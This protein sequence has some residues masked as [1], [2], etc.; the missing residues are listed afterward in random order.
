MSSRGRPATIGIL[1]AASL[2]VVRDA[3]AQAT[4]GAWQIGLST[5]ALSYTKTTITTDGP[6]FSNFDN[7]QTSF[8]WGFGERSNLGLDLGHG[9]GDNFVLGAFLALQGQAQSQ[10]DRITGRSFRH[11]EFS[12]VAGPRLDWLPLP[13]SKVRPF[14]GVG[15]GIVRSNHSDDSSTLST[16]ADP[17]ARPIREESPSGMSGW[18]LVS[19]LGIRW[20]LNPHFSIDPALF[21]DGSITSDDGDGTGYELRQTNLV[22]GL[23]I[24]GSGWI[25][26]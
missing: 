10:N 5:R 14:I 15:A 26:P 12:L 6:V 3:G 9:L 17:G 20:F 24:G 16:W 2:L 8:A 7:G 22:F 23:G 13:A 18:A 21:F 1:T 25:G 4:G 11:S 19:R